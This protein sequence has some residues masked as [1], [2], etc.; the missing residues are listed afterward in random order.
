MYSPEVEMFSY[1]YQEKEPQTVAEVSPS[2]GWL[3]VRCSVTM[4]SH[5]SALPFSKVWVYSPETVMLSCSY[6]EKDSQAVAEVS[7]SVG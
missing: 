6:Q 3:M 7:P 2:V 1:S 4:L 5:P